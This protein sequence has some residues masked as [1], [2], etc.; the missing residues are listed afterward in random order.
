MSTQ[1]SQEGIIVDYKRPYVLSPLGV[2]SLLVLFHFSLFDKFR[3][4][5]QIIVEFLLIHFDVLIDISGYL[6][7]VSGK[8]VW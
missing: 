7:S 5:M 6:N 2:L 8:K 4:E 3:P 1:R